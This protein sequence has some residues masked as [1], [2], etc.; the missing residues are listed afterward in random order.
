MLQFVLLGILYQSVTCQIS[1]PCIESNVASA[2]FPTDYFQLAH[3]KSKNSIYIFG[4][5]NSGGFTNKIWKWSD[6]SQEPFFHELP[7]LMTPTDIFYSLTQNIVVVDN[8]AYFASMFA[9]AG[10]SDNVYRFDVNTESWESGF[11]PMP[12]TAVHGCVVTNSS[13]MFII[14]G[15]DPP[16]VPLDIIQVYNI[17]SDEWSEYNFGISYGLSESMCTMLNNNMFI[18]GG[19]SNEGSGVRVADTI[20]KVQWPENTWELVGYLPT[21]VRCSASVLHCDVNVILTGGYIGATSGPIKNII[22]VFGIHKESSNA[23]LSIHTATNASQISGVIVNDK[24]HIFAGNATICP[25]DASVCGLGNKI[26]TW[27]IIGIIVGCI[28]LIGV[29][30]WIFVRYRKKRR[31]VI[32]DQNYKRADMPLIKR[33]DIYAPKLYE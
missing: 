19:N 30:Y 16:L 23:S 20:Y 3:F 1:G 33:D 17:D 8:Y 32:E 28:V 6:T 26:N 2:L 24:M 12:T 29:T 4:G 9:E 10:N 13:H 11:S 18:F 31:D 25:L 21:G 5:Y 7:N 27:S 15:A 14:G 22:Q